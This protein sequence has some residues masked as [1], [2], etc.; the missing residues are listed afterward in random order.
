VY[1]ISQTRTVTEWL[2]DRLLGDP[3]RGVQEQ[4]WSV[5]RNLAEDEAGIDMVFQRLDTDVLF[6][7]LTIALGSKDGDILLQVC[8]RICRFFFCILI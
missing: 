5:V 4:A 8:V 2:R 7:H 1:F 3:E 6:N